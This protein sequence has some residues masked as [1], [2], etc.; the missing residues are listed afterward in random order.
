[1]WCIIYSWILFSFRGHK[2][3]LSSAPNYNFIRFRAL[4]QDV[5]QDFKRI[6]EEIIKIEC[7]LRVLHPDLSMYLA[8]VQDSEKQHL[9]L[10]R[11]YC[12]ELY[13]KLA[14]ERLTS[15]N[16]DCSLTISKTRITRLWTQWDQIKIWWYSAG[17]NATE[18]KACWCAWKN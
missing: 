12:Q 14:S 6:S 11:Y 9:E 16:L 18:E 17:N 3:Y 1:M 8:D 2:I 13:T 10:V 4:V 7:E 15:F 5:T